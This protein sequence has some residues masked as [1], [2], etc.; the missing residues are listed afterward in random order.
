MKLEQ[1]TRMYKDYEILACDEHTEIHVFDHTGTCIASFSFFGWEREDD[2]YK[3]SCDGLG[4]SRDAIV[5]AY[6]E[7]YCTICRIH[8]PEYEQAKALFIRACKVA[9]DVYWQWRENFE[10]L[11]DEDFKATTDIAL[12]IDEM[13]DERL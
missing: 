1:I 12:A 7:N 13:L 8:S 11:S 2:E 9:R 3:P 6:A 10:I 4:E 5:D